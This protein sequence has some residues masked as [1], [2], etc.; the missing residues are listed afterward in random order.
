MSLRN[1]EERST[2]RRH[3][4]LV[5]S[6]P[7]F[8]S[9]A[10]TSGRQLIVVN[11]A[12]D[13]VGSYVT[14]LLLEKGYYIRACVR[15]G[16]DAAFLE[17]LPGA[18]D[19]L[20]LVT[21]KDFHSKDSTRRLA[22]ALRGCSA[23]VHTTPVGVQMKRMSALM[24]S[25][26]VMDSVDALID[27]AS[28]KD[29]TVKRIV[30]VSSEMSV[31]D[32]LGNVTPGNESRP[33]RASQAALGEED[34]YDVSRN[35]RVASDYF[36][37]AHTVAEMKLWS[38]S[39]RPSIPFTVCSVVPTFAIGPVLSPVQISTAHPM[40]FLHSMMA[41][42]FEE[43]PSV[44]FCPIDVRDVAD[45]V[46]KLVGEYN[47]IT[48]RILACPR[49]FTTIEFIKKCKSI[50]QRYPWPKQGVTGAWPALF[51]LKK[52]DSRQLLKTFYFMANCRHERRYS[53]NNDRLKELGHGRFRNLDESL[54]EAMDSIVTAA[55]VKD[56]RIQASGPKK[57]D[58]VKQ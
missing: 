10:A 25:S 35:D 11:G 58:P 26:R 43:I 52:A 48:G 42:R 27:A 53:F 29:S 6:T 38:R 37:Y 30:Y 56:L 22:D 47:Q 17:Q 14:K 16:I 12:T 40:R 34:W 5:D 3:P 41:G 44:P 55:C 49:D 4:R 46:V 45:I 51:D 36:A 39:T 57:P 23:V 19:R 1:T 33:A 54:R 7:G 32:P 13:F 50:Y 8:S 31:F 18:M 28:G 21:L 15:A 24:P 9:A 20:Q 2:P